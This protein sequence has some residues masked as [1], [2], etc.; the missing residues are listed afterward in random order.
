MATDLTAAAKRR[1]NGDYSVAS[2]GVYQHELDVNALADAYAAELDDTPVKAESFV[3]MFGQHNTMNGG[4]IWWQ[5]A[6]D[7]QVILLNGEYRIVSYLSSLYRGST[8]G[9]LRTD[10]RRMGIDWVNRNGI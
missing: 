1:R 2:N 10:I 5:I 6:E 3:S 8:M 9:E 7:V 4:H